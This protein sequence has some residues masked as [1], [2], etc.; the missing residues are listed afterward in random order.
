M[1]LRS[2]V[3]AWCCALL[4]A[5]S[6]PSGCACGGFTPL[7]QGS[8][9]GT[10]VNS[11]GSA[12]LSAQGFEA[13]NQNAP[14]I[15]E[16]FAPGGTLEVP[17]P[18]SVQQVSIAGF[19]VVQLVVADT[20]DFYCAAESCG[21]M[22]GTCTP[23][24]SPREDLGHT[25]TL[26]FTS[27]EFAPRAPDIL[28]A[29]VRASVQTGRLPISSRGSGSSP[30][31]LLQGGRAKFTV[32][33][34]TARRPPAFTDL[35][36]DIRFA[37]DQRWDQLLSLEVAAV[38]NTTACGGS[39]SPP[40]CI[41]PDDIEILNEG[42]S[43][44]NIAQLSV[45]KT[46]L[47]NQLA[48]SLRTQLTEA[49]ADANC[50]SCG[51]MGECPT[52]GMA[53][54]TCEP[55]AG[56]C[57][58]GMTGRCVPALIGLEGRLEVGQALGPLGAPAG[59]AIELSI[60]AGG[61]ATASDAG[62]TVGL[63]GGAKEVAVAPCVAPLSRPTPPMLALPDFEPDA[64]G[65]YDVGLS[66]SNQFLD[67]VL[68]RAQ[69]SGALCL[70]LGTE[71]VSAL[72]SGLLGTLLPSLNLLTE[73]RNVPLRVVIRP[74][75]P[76]T[77]TVGLGTVGSDGR[78]LDPLLRLT[79]RGLELDVYALLEDRLAR[80]FTVA[81][82]LSLP[83]GLDLDGCATITPVVGSLMGAVTSVQVKNAELL[84]EPLSALQNL[85][86][87]LLTLAEPQLA[88]GLQS[89][90][91]PDFNGFG[92]SF[93]AARGIGRITGTQTFNHLALYA[94]LLGQGETCVTQPLKASA[95]VVR[96]VRPV[97]ASAAALDLAPAAEVSWRVDEGLWS[98][99]TEVDSTGQL[100][101][102]HP[103]LRLGGRHV[104]EVRTK[105]GERQRVELPAAA[106]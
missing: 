49:L 7:P 72:E 98:T 16:F 10:K 79:W 33:L 48:A 84:A 67:D 78:P 102:E 87:S 85:V 80:L 41:D 82:D 63:R 97:G 9:S 52:H 64:P 53:T 22:D 76:P 75:T 47:V 28:E 68:F 31:C 92:F 6:A 88:S 66:V 25:V 99:W 46:L 70:E 13:L 91:V 18:C 81:A 56:H 104:V 11:A 95:L 60:G 65:P 59:A 71:T 2:W 89:F 20:G 44:L 94:D 3:F 50:A 24:G 35:T 55:D 51:P 23:L 100:L 15:L 93:L 57:L 45:V 12:R 5:C 86:P 4:W 19:N 105:R 61:G 30:L 77:A 83:L 1:R 58:D 73:G 14:S 42:C 74:V 54:S 37:I 38:G 29:R 96:S 40:N 34:D 8:Y 62:L 39:S 21:R 26:T 17:V 36:L 43:A 103:R 27:L 69:Q 106:P 32:D 101:V 90:T